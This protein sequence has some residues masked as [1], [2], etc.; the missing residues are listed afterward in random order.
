MENT[1][2]IERGKSHAFY[3]S[4]LLCIVHRTGVSDMGHLC[5]YVAIPTEHPL[6][7]KDYSCDDIATLHVHGGVTFAD[8]GDWPNVWLIGFDTNHMFDRGN[9]PGEDYAI[10]QTKIL[11]E[12]I[13]KK[14]NQNQ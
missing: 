12:Q 9:H 13:A 7:G 10:N 2:K 6:H 1:I 8:W 5:G 3:H 14:G 11:A 4:G